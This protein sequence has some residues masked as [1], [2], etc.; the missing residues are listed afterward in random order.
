[1]NRNNE[2]GM[3]AAVNCTQFHIIRTIYD[4]K[5]RTNVIKRNLNLKFLSEG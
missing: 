2:A 5:S 1:M 4:H 3:F